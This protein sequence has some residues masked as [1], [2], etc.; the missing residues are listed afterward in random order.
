MWKT[1]VVG[2]GTDDASVMMESN[3]GKVK[4]MKDQ[5]ARPYILAV[6]CS[7]HRLELAYKD[8][9]KQIAL[10]EKVSLKLTL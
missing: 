4:K 10:Y 3:N 7:A 9:C 1:K 5:L 6:H 8:A 2:F